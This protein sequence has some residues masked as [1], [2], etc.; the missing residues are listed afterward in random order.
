MYQFDL[1]I[2]QPNAKFMDVAYYEKQISRS[3]QKLNKMKQGNL[4][5]DLRNLYKDDPQ[6]IK[7][8]ETYESQIKK[9][10]KAIDGSV[11]IIQ[12]HKHDL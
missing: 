6:S 11:N 7:K 12:M 8:I 4:M 10:K 5:V 2:I 1:T 9:A 3:Q